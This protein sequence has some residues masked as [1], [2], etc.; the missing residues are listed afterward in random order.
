MAANITGVAEPLAETIVSSYYPPGCS[1]VCG[2]NRWAIK[3]NKNL[4]SSQR[5]SAFYVCLCAGTCTTTSTSTI[6]SSTTTS[7]TSST[8]TLTTS[9]T[10]STTSSTTS[11]TT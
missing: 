4:F 9:T 3:F 5:C 8:T 10:T 1:A 7:T 11:V 2:G 6:T